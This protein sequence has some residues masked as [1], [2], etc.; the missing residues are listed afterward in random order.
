[1]TK[2]MYVLACAGL[3]AGLAMGNTPSLLRPADRVPYPTGYRLWT[4]V[5]SMVVLPSSPA[6]ATGG[7]MHHIYANATAMA[8]FS[9]GRFAD[10]S[11][12]VF[13]LLKASE[14]SGVIAAADRERLDVMIKDSRRYAE[15]GGW[16]FERFVGNDTTPSLTEEHRTQ[17]VECHDQRAEHDRVFST[18]V[19]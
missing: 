17:C 15:S 11:V 14:N 10:G 2:L 12:L 6:F 19:R 9:T 13:D 16:G 8:G 4:H 5:K 3:A 7:G 18:F 1:M